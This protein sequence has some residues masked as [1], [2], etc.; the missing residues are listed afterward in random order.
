MLFTYHYKRAPI[1][2]LHDEVRRFMRRLRKQPLATQFRIQNWCQ[3]VLLER[4]QSAPTLKKH[5][6]AFYK[7]YRTLNDAERTTLHTA[8]TRTNCVSRQLNG[9]TPRIAIDGLPANIRK[10]T[11]DLFVHLYESTLR[12][13]N[14]CRDHWREFYAELSD[15]TCP[16]CGTEIL[17]YPDHYKQDYDHILCKKDYP[18][19]SVNMRNLV[20]MGRDCNTIFKADTDVIYDEHGPRRFPDPFGPQL[21][22]SIDLSGSQ[23]PRGSANPG[24]WSLQILPASDEIKRWAEVF[25]L[26]SRYEKNHLDLKY[27]DWISEF[28]SWAA[29]KRTKTS[30]WTEDEVR[31][32]LP[33]YLETL[34]CKP[35]V[36]QNFLK[37]AVFKLI[38]SENS[39]SFLKACARSMDYEEQKLVTRL[40]NQST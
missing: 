34:E 25:N 40:N 10:P 27:A 37:A 16:F 11:K 39:P 30:P 4:A 38:I 12:S 31:T 35:L 23:R 7:S 33:I 22:I 6:T 32:Y 9:K 2:D 15:K 29:G 3:G 21:N 8:F 26:A 14:A 1:N 20:P 17:H 13:R 28:H 19:A 36:Q 18:F 24:Q 5:L